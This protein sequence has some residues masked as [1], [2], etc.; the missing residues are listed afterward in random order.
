MPKYSLSYPNVRKHSNGKYFI[1]FFLNN[2][3]YRLFNGKRIGSSLAPNSYPS[4]L[5]HSKTTL[6]AKEVY[7]YLVSNDYSFKRYLKVL[8]CSIVLL[9]LSFVNQYL[10]CI[11]RR[12]CLLHRF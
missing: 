11:E 1:D 4:K 6:L 5:R 12:L 10:Q 2:K 8:I 3:R 9:N 7:D